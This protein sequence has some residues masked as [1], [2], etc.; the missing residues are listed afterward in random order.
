MTSKRAGG[1][2]L[3]LATTLWCALTGWVL[4]GATADPPAPT[5]P[6]CTGDVAANH[7]DDDGATRW[8]TGAP[9][10]PGQYVEVD[11]GRTGTVRRVVLDAG[12]ATGD[13]PRG[14]ALSLSPDG[15]NWGPPRAT[16]A[17]SGQLT[18]IDVPAATARY[19]RVTLTQP[20]PSWWSVADLRVYR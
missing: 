14:Y 7:V 11:L 20:A 6:C 1:L 13:Y 18:T 19:L 4:L 9:Q 8:T 10:Q 16:G 17:G 15:V 12:P 3:A 5:D 2:G